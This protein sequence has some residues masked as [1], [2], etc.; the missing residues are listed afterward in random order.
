MNLHDEVCR[1]ISEDTIC[2]T[3]FY[4]WPIPWVEMNAIIVGL[5]SL[6]LHI[7]HHN[8]CSLTSTPA[9]REHGKGWEAEASSVL[10]FSVP[11]SK[12]QSRAQ[13]S[14]AEKICVRPWTGCQVGGLSTV[15]VHLWSG[16]F[17]DRFSFSHLHE[18]QIMFRLRSFPS[19]MSQHVR[20]EDGGKYFPATTALSYYT[21]PMD[22]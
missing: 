1:C 11:F 5:F 16:G 14:S 17:Q 20:S 15:A 3:A 7:Q 12:E 13:S 6:D 4:W 18:K 9:D 22:Y 10:A 21:L 2:S 8:L 19:T